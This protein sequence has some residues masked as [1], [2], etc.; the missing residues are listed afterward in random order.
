[1][2]GGLLALNG[3]RIDAGEEKKVQKFNSAQLQAKPLDVAKLWNQKHKLSCFCE[4]NRTKV[5]Y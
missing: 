1:M 5:E 2:S 4:E 3:M